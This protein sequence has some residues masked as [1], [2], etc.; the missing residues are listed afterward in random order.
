VTA[1]NLITTGAGTLTKTGNGTLQLA[2]GTANTQTGV[3]AVNQGT[4]ELNKTAAINAISGSALTIGGAGSNAT[5]TLLASNQ[6]ANTTAVTVTSTS[7]TAMGVF[8][9]NG[10]SDT[11]ASLTMTASTVQGVLV[12]TGASGV[13]TVTGDITLNNN[14][15][16]NDASSNARNIVITGTGDIG[17]AAPNTGT[18]NLGGATRTITVQSTATG[19]SIGNLDATIETVITNGGIIKEGD[20]ALVLSANNTYTGAT[21]VNNGELHLRNGSLAAGAVTVSETGGSLTNAAVLS[22]TGSIGGSVIIGEA[23]CGVGILAVGSVNSTTTLVSN[24]GAGANGTLELTAGGPALTVADGSQIQ[25][26][27]TNAT[28]VSTGLAAVLASGA[29]TTAADYANANATE[30]SA[31]WNVAPTSTS[32]MDFLNLSGSGSSLSIGDRASGTFGDGS[33][34]VS[35]LSL[36]APAYGQVFNLI[37]WKSASIIGGG[38]D[39]GGSSSYLALGNIIAGDLDLPTL[40]SG[41]WAWDVSLF[42]SHGILVVVPEPSRALFLLLGLLGLMLRRRR[43]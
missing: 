18:L 12:T 36:A 9:L 14:R 34:R 4:L 19:A 20:R 43:R 23:G 2:G 22:G 26:G 10:F 40:G 39:T 6:I 33:V 8:N 5:V 35:G 15:N 7:T 32:D 28:Y 24:Y 27:I 29:Y 42:A 41:G 17:T 13:L 3:V 30:F 11:I 25:L 16:L 1:T 31:S 38:F 37:D 21:T